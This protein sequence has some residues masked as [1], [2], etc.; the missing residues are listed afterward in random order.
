[1]SRRFRQAIAVCGGC[2]FAATILLLG[3]SGTAGAYTNWVSYSA[4]DPTTGP[5]DGETLAVTGA[6]T[7]SAGSTG[8]IDILECVTAYVPS[9]GSRLNRA[10]CDS[11]NIVSGIR[12]DLSAGDYS[13]YFVFDVSFVPTA[14][15]SQVDCSA[16][17]ACE[18]VADASPPG[19]VA[20]AMPMKGVRACNGAFHGD[21]VGSLSKSTQPP[22]G[23][24]S[25]DP[26]TLPTVSPGQTITASLSWNT[27]N[28]VG[29]TSEASDCIQ[30]GGV[31]FDT[32]ASES[33][34]G[35]TPTPGTTK[36]I[37]TYT[38]PASASAGSI[39]CDRGR[40]SGMPT[41]ANPTTQK[42]NVVC[43]QVGPPTATPESRAPIAAGL[44]GMGLVCGYVIKRRRRTFSSRC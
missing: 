41:G 6:Y 8:P 29:Q 23:T 43:F 21:P 40:V 31:D 9:D 10:W 17:G 16:S 15:G 22:G 2:G 3:L 19:D 4:S 39:I 12:P 34:P 18:L 26:N 28:F 32:L 30:V 1:V 5:F 25:Q 33:K 13:S 24:S 44:V 27:A 14:T 11:N 37:S 42:S 38:V 20:A 35:P 36:Y 7:N